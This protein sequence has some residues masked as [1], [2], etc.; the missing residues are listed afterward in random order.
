QHGVLKDGIAGFRG[1]PQN[2]GDIRYV[3]I[4]E[5]GEIFTGNNTLED[6][7]D[8]TIIGNTN[9][10]YQFGINGTASYKGFDLSFFLQGIGKR[11]L[12]VSNEMFWPYTSQF[13]TV[14]KHH[15][16][17][18]TLENPDG[19]FPRNYP[20]A[21]GNAGSSRRVQTKYLSN[22]AY[23]NVKN[24]TLGYAVPSKML[25]NIFIKRARLFFSG[26]NLYTFHHMPK[27]MDTEATSQSRGLIYPFLRKYSFGVN[28]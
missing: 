14:Y 11:D 16:D 17:Y 9:R 23:L 15:L 5:D 2:P 25:D 26:E 24:I 8:R 12:F 6:S 7:G 19:F 1:I 18:W 21:G 27:G 28:V 3:D 13:E 20:D 22:G 4:N 10:R